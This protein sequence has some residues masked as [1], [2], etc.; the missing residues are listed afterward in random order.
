W[1]EGRHTGDEALVRRGID[2]L[3]ASLALQQTDTLEARMYYFG[4]QN[5]LADA[6]ISL[7]MLRQDN[8]P[9]LDSIV[10]S[11]TVLAQI[12]RNALPIDWA[13][14]QKHVG[15]AYFAMA[16]RLPEPTQSMREA[17]TAYRAALELLDRSIA[18]RDWSDVQA[19]LSICLYNLGQSDRTQLP[20]AL[21][22]A[23]AALAGYRS[24]N[25]YDHSGW[26]LMMIRDIQ[27]AASRQPS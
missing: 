11:R 14:A 26:A 19:Q 23:Q 15:D 4:T 16:P 27:T 8:Q 5:N 12:D 24:L 17:V 7:G 3:R 22:A 1:R 10:T 9:L 6:L 13:V 20:G 18:E 21:E 25:D 2:A